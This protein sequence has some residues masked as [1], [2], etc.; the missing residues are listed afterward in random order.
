MCH[1]DIQANI[2]TDFGYGNPW[3]MGG[4]STGFDLANPEQTQSWF[5]NDDST[6]FSAKQILGTVYVPNAPINSSAM[7]MLSPT[8][9]ATPTIA[10][11]MQTPYVPQNHFDSDA[12]AQSMAGKV[13]PAVAGAAPVKGL[14]KIVI[15]APTEAEITSIDPAFFAGP[16]GFELK[17]TGTAPALIVKNNG[18]GEFVTNDPSQP[19]VCSDADILVNGSLFLNNLNVS[20][21][22]G[23][24]FY[25]TGTVFVQDAITYA[26]GSG[27]VQITS[28]RAIVMGIGQ[29]QLN[30]RLVNDHRT[31]YLS[32]LD[33]STLTTEV[34]ADAA[35]IGNLVDAEGD[36]TTGSQQNDSSNNLCAVVNY[37]GLIAER[38]DRSQPV[39]G[40]F[41]GNHHRGSSAVLT[42]KF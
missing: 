2:I 11:F 35:T 31:I 1:A 13:T 42:G 8:P 10:E 20:A 7:A 9:A 23:C 28:S 16:V 22:K 4:T 40:K 14:S 34:L 17:G 30:N 5:N 33:Y 29:S 18:Q 24:R 32:Q 21:A 36:T 6:W 38:A 15:R 3:F 12:S 25:V 41:Q 26:G 37:S 19:L 27:N 39:S